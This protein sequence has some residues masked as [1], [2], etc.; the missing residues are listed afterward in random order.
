MS[1]TPY[2]TTGVCWQIDFAQHACLAPRTAAAYAAL[3]DGAA[4][5]C[6][7]FPR[8]PTPGTD[9]CVIRDTGL[10]GLWGMQLSVF[11]HGGITNGA[12]AET[13]LRVSENWDLSGETLR[14]FENLP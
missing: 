3:S 8:A 11:Q 2:D 5:G 6:G 13:L 9:E 4:A 10:R 7:A 14:A 1:R 12:G